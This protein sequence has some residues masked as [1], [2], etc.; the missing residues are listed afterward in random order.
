MDKLVTLYKKA[1]ASGMMMKRTIQDI[2]TDS[3]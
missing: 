1:E 2:L 3:F